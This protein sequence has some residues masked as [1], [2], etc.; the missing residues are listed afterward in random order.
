MPEDAAYNLAAPATLGLEHEGR[1]DAAVLVSDLG[2][3]LC[4]AR[5]LPHPQAPLTAALRD[6]RRVPAHVLAVDG[7]RDL[8]LI[9]LDAPGPFP[10]LPLGASVPEP[11]TPVYAVFQPAALAWSGT[12]GTVQQR[13]ALFHGIADP[14]RFVVRAATP[15]LGEGGP[16]VDLDGNLVGLVAAPEPGQNPAEAVALS[17]DGLR[18]FLDRAGVYAPGFALLIS[19]NPPGAQ[20]SVDGHPVGMTSSQPVRAERLTLGRH[21]V[22]LSVPGLPEDVVSVELV[23]HQAETLSRTLDAG[24]TL[25]V[26]VNT[27][28]DVWIDGSMR[29]EAPLQLK[30]PSGRHVVDLRANGYL[31]ASR[32]VEVGQGATVPV[33]VALERITAD[34]SLNTVPPGADVAANGEPVGKTPLAHAHVPA[35]RIELSLHLDGFH[36]YR[37]P[38]QLAPREERDLGTYRL[39]PP[40]GWLDAH[41]PSGSDIAIDGGP[42]HFPQS[43]E[44]LAVGVHRI[45]VFAPG[46]YAY[47]EKVSVGDA[48][49]VLL[50]PPLK[51]YDRLPARRALGYGMTGL[52]LSLGLVSIGLASDDSSRNWAVPAVL[53]GITALGIGA[54]ALLSAG[55]SDEA[56]WDEERSYT[57]AAPST[58]SAP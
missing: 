52:G 57:P 13:F 30:L 3:A 42:Q 21:E 49:T 9:Q 19:T 54:W 12:Q 48:Q 53:S 20:V 31:P 35:G 43:N 1:V 47:S 37:F 44:R 45:Q 11:G 58:G 17:V 56:G 22:R 36:S 29:G 24:G 4:T 18:V 25:A 8:A 50:D 55:K 38:V 2:L 33:D 16:V 40:Y 51:L 7:A 23:R 14:L 41:L 27:R 46:Y 10:T 26:T 5:A 15:V 39:E 34:L 32:V 28:A 6:G